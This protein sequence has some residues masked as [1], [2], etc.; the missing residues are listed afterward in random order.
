MTKEQ[1][2]ER[3]EK[4]DIRLLGKQASAE[5]ELELATKKGE[6]IYSNFLK[7][8]KDGLGSALVLLE[9]LLEEIKQ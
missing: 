3:I 4:I 5:V 6:K 8:Q 9:K 1:I 2:I 7:G